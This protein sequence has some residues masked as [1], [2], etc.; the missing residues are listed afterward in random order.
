MLLVCLC[1]RP[2][3]SGA[4]FLVF[5]RAAC[6]LLVLSLGSVFVI[7]GGSKGLCHCYAAFY[8]CVAADFAPISIAFAD[9][10]LSASCTFALLTSCVRLCGVYH[11]APCETDYLTLTYQLPDFDILI[12][13]AERYLPDMATLAGIDH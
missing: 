8:L 12:F 2:L 11:L 4:C 5:R 6:S 9:Q 3:L 7:P 10:P 1:L 13:V